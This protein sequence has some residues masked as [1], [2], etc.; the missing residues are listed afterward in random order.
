MTPNIVD[1]LK[2][3]A[4]EIFLAGIQA[5]D[6]IFAVKRALKL[7]GSVLE[8]DGVTYDLDKFKRIIVIGAGKA[9][10]SMARAVEDII[11]DRITTGYVNVKY[12]HLD[13]VKTIKIHEAGHPTPDQ[14][15]NDGAKKIYDILQETTVD[16]LVIFLL[17]GGGSALL[18]LPA[19]NISLTEKQQT[20]N[21][22]L[23]CGATINEI[24]AVRK[25]ISR[26]KGGRL[27]NHA[28]P[29]PL[30]TLIISDVIG[31]PLDAIASGPTV[32]DPTTFGDC[33]A[34]LDKYDIADKV[35][36]S[37][38]QRINSGL[39]G[40]IKET[41]KPDESVFQNAQNVI[42]ANNTMA[43]KAAQRKTV[44]LGYN[45]LMLSTMIEGETREVAK[46]HAG[47]A[48]EI[49]KSGNP[50]KPPA[51][52]LS[53]GETTVTIRGR[54]LGGRNQEFVLAASIEIAGLKNTI[55]FSAATDG[56]DGPLNPAGAVADGS[57]SERAQ[58]LNLDPNDYLKNN[59]SYRFFLTLGDL[60][61]TG[62]TNTN[63]MDIRIMLVV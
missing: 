45:T 49:R 48:K 16:D 2:N 29:S 44:E 60:I 23:S 46:V 11:G 36:D 52:L 22:L 38:L 32:P 51:C 56:T 6:P 35:P 59:D 4:W 42:I 57:T 58:K 27:A 53:G 31:D 17:S 30:V 62:P 3:D 54:G 47:I 18:P 63:V 21:L 19:N 5:V 8:I 61:T 7:S 25:H 39:S 13:K 41:P 15:G 37:I 20:T 9:G 10:A 40:D 43:F 14:A 55:V 1:K 26:L 34:I 24:N 33:M 28:Y 50:V 12:G